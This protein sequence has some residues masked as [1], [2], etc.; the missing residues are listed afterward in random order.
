MEQ[1]DEF[2]M[3][4]NDVEAALTQVASL[5]RPLPANVVPSEE[6]MRRTRLRLLKLDGTDRRT[7]S[8]Q[9]A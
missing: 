6:F 4:R 9:A 1:Q 5:I 8:Q 2:T 7:S 3:K